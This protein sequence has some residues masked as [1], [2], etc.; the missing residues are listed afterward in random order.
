M[1]PQQWTQLTCSCCTRAAAAV[2]LLHAEAAAFLLV[3]FVAGL[4]RSQYEALWRYWSYWEFNMLVLLL[5]RRLRSLKASAKWNAIRCMGSP[6]GDEI[7]LKW[8]S[9]SPDRSYSLAPIASPQ[10]NN[11]CTSWSPPL[12]LLSTWSRC[13]SCPAEDMKIWDPLWLVLV[14]VE[15][16]PNWSPLQ[17]IAT[18]LRLWFKFYE[19]P[20]RRLDWSFVVNTGCCC[21]FVHCIKQDILYVLYVLYNPH[22]KNS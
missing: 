11:R 20:K 4:T 15:D 22:F 19:R 18:L 6:C 7:A 13:C 12:V 14:Y 5:C 16:L 8:Q 2:G 21:W 9:K 1:R 3:L 10:P 17:L